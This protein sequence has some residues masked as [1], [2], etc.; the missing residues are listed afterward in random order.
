MPK[1]Y[2]GIA[3][4]LP[5]VWARARSPVVVRAWAFYSVPVRISVTS[6]HALDFQVFGDIF[7]ISLSCKILFLYLVDHT[8]A[9]ARLAPQ[10][11]ARSRVFSQ[12]IWVIMRARVTRR[13]R[14][15]IVS[16]LTV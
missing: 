15:L 3:L 8:H 1:Y 16:V 2:V 11:L 14:Y 12:C 10:N 13:S 9:R 4:S 5:I 6:V 7:L